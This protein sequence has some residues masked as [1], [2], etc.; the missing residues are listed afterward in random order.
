MSNSKKN[1]LAF[2]IAGSTILASSAQ[3][4]DTIDLDRIVVTA[5]PLDLPTIQVEPV[6]PFSM[7]DIFSWSPSPDQTVG[8][9]PSET[10]SWDPACA[11]L[12]AAVP[13]NCT[14][15]FANGNMPQFV[16]LKPWQLTQIVSEHH[17]GSSFN[18][19][20]GWTDF[21]LMNCYAD[22]VND[23]AT[24]EANYITALENWGNIYGLSADP[25]FSSGIE[26]YQA[27]HSVAASERALLGWVNRVISGV[28]IQFVSVNLPTV[29]LTGNNRGLADARRFRNCDQFVSA[30]DDLGCGSGPS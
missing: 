7:F 5:S 4:G 10:S 22:A 16:H 30:W 3:A 11:S 20:W 27:Q 19:I 12:Q 26:T 21:A 28:N 18:T 23:P 6:G 17:F 15:A 14:R 29:G 9:S 8:I 1:F 24:C 2:C 25:R 13:D